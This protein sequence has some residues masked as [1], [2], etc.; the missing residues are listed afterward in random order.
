[1]DII[2]I[3]DV[4]ESLRGNELVSLW[5]DGANARAVRVA[6]CLSES[7]DRG[8]LAEAR[9][10]LV[11]VVKRWSEAGAGAIQQQTA[12]P[13]SM[14]VDTRQ[15]GGFSLWPSEITALQEICSAPTQRQAFSIDTAPTFA[16]A[17]HADICSLFFNGGYCSCGADIAGSPLWERMEP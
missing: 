11:G 17:N 16:Y 5:L 8:A 2:T 7:E 3:N 1:M 6:P 15:R 13:F 14:G 12:G 4:P 10:I 9:L